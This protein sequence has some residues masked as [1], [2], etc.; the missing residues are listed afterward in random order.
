MNK[1]KPTLLVMAAGMGSRYGGLKQIDPVGSAGEIILDF[2]V[3]DAMMAGFEKAVF[4]I[5]REN[6]KDFRSLIDDRCGKF[7][8]V[9]YAFQERSDLPEGFTVPSERVKPWGT[10]Q[11][12]LAARREISGPFAVINSDDYYGPLAFQLIYEALSASPERVGARRSEAEEPASPAP[13]YMVAYQIEKTLSENGG[14]S[15]GVCEIDENSSLNSIEETHG[16]A[17]NEKKTAAVSEGGREIAF[18]TPVSMNLWGLP[19]SFMDEA[20][21]RF[22]DFLRAALKENPLKAEYA[23]PTVISEI[24]HEGKAEVRA[25]RTS[26]KWHG[27]TYKEDKEA[28]VSALQAM[29]DAGLY[30]DK[31]WK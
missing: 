1:A 24:M 9:S 27:V 21:R 2:S 16:I 31:L 11:A 29:K 23:L 10:A 4:V 26:D 15:R 3:Y 17:L 13:Y 8:E 12:V 6:E 18:G 19:E 25:L 5:K 30:P 14:V 22:P 7:I 20:M 28:V